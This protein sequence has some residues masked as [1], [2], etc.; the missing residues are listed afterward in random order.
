MSTAMLT[1]ARG[2]E[3]KRH[4]SSDREEKGNATKGRRRTTS[5]R[6]GVGKGSKR[7]EGQYITTN[8]MRKTAKRKKRRG[9]RSRRGNWRS[10]KIGST[11]AVTQPGGEDFLVYSARV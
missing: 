6:P 9:G 10:E 8:V 1:R 5:C 2:D 11:S 3:E 7:Q 4:G